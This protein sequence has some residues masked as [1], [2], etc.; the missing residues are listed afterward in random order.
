MKKLFLPAAIAAMM[1]VGGYLGHTTAT[2]AEG[3]SDLQLENAEAL[4]Y[5]EYIDGSIACFWGIIDAEDLFSPPTLY[6]YSCYP[7]GIPHVADRVG[8]GGTCKP[9]D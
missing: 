7:C 9:F 1:G 5:T 3:L 2:P 6:V 4:A 8:H